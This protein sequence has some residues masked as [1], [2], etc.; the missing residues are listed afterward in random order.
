MRKIF[1]L[2]LWLS[3]LPFATRGQTIEDIAL[4][5][6]LHPIQAKALCYWYDDNTDNRQVVNN[7]SGTYTLDVSSLKDGLH[8]LYYQVIGTDDMSYGTT[9]QMFFR[10]T[11]SEEISSIPLD[12]AQLKYWYDEDTDNINAVNN[13]L[14][15]YSL[16]VSTLSDGLHT[17]H[18]ILVGA[19][20]TVCSTMSD[21]FIKDESIQ[22]EESLFPV[23]AARRVAYWF[24]DDA[25]NIQVSKGL[26]GT[27]K[28]DVSSLSDGLHLLHY[29]VVGE[30]GLPYGMTSTMF[31]KNESMY[32]QNTP[33]GITKY[34]YWLN[35]FST[36]VQTVT[37]DKTVNPYT[38]MT[39]LPAPKQPIRSSKFHF[40]V[41][42]GI[43]YIYAKN[44][45]H[46]RFYD[47][48]GEFVDNF[49]EEDNTYI[50]YSVKQEVT[51]ITLLESGVRAT[52][53]K[54]EENAIKW[55]KVT[56]VK[57]DSL[58][59]KLDRAATLQL[60]SPSGEEVFN[61]SGAESVKWGGCH[62]KEDGTFYVALHDVTAT[63][64]NDISIDYNHIDKY[65]V[66]RQD[67]N[68]VGNGGCS[69]I[70]FEGN[71][72]KDLYAVD[73]FNERGDTI[74]H[75]YIGHESDATTS[76]VFDFSDAILGIYSAKFR[77]AEEDKVFN[78]MVTVEE[79]KE[80]ELETTVTYP[81]TFL[82]G[83]STTYNIKITNKGNMTAYY[84]PLILRL[85][86]NTISDI[87]SLSI[88]GDIETS[89]ITDDLIFNELDEETINTIYKATNDFGN[90]PELAYYEDRDG[91]NVY[92]ITQIIL[93]IP[94]Y[95]TKDIVVN[96]KTSTTISLEASTS[97]E[98]QPLVIVASENAPKPVFKSKSDWLC[99]YRK[100]AECVVDAVSLLI[101]PG[102]SCASSVGIGALETIYDVW[103]SE[104]TNLSEKW[105]T[106][107][108]SKD[109][110]L[111]KRIIQ[112]VLSCVT[113]YFKNLKDKTIEDR[114]NAAISGDIEKVERL[115]NELEKIRNVEQGWIGS[116]F[117][118][119]KGLFVGLIGSDCYKAWS[120]E[121][122]CSPNST[123]GGGTSSPQRSYDPN[124]I[125]GY[126]AESGSHAVK[127]ELTNLYYTIQFEN[128][129]TF[130][131]AAAHDIY[132]TDTLDATKFD[133]ST[134]APTRVK[135]GEKA[136]NFTG[137]KNFVTTIDMRPE[138][139]AIAQVE[140]T[141]D[142]KKGIAMWHI[143]SLDP[144]TMEPTD[145]PMDGVLPINFNGNGIG[146]VSYDI[147][148]KSD[149]AHGTE[150]NN[151]AGIVFDKN[152]VIM[153]PTWKNVIDRISPESC[154]R[155]VTISSDTTATVSI[156]AKDELS[157]VWRYDVYV[158]YGPDA[159]WWKMAENV[160]ADT[161]A[162]VKIYEGIN[163]GFYVVVTDSAGNVEHKDAKREFTLNR[164]TFIRGDV[165]SDG[166][167]N[168]TDIQVIINFILVGR[169][170][171]KADLNKD[172]IVNGTDIQEIIN[173]IIGEE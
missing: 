88:N 172:G 154:I 62:A 160:P 91:N 97:K 1:F 95:T 41:N 168:G 99:C 84:L 81:S 137:D 89:S 37:L 112:S 10:M 5:E 61:A 78:N 56:A 158:Q 150:I 19:D 28:I 146:E 73:L 24:D 34:T 149:L 113:K 106:Y 102:A 118:G 58:Q 64:G 51:D 109:N 50:D 153:T 124:E 70:T 107:F 22:T 157:G 129:T 53:A 116:F 16:D 100:R 151:R 163:H 117:K 45:F 29:Y 76:V 136:A 140:G 93:T 46:I 77:F 47:A 8:T 3:C 96:V 67:V 18:A 65:A 134:F 39:L 35:D 92:G 142:D 135:I 30:D 2:F 161:T 138:I 121:L 42:D 115:T 145:D 141:F 25:N 152:D 83:S 36:P 17:L 103:C 101:P 171:E 143:S 44:D 98:W 173:I 82:Y 72:F 128:D 119:V 54:P 32:A 110:N 167:I 57:G 111:L 12:G 75:V 104:G 122:D 66:L 108:N 147:K 52:I 15:I 90:V 130:A 144:M 148:L 126:T 133:L 139:N 156:T 85:M 31:L 33:N 166:N 71:G 40:Q 20:G 38:L 123:G 7:L 169:Y 74:H 68:V 48:R 94:P 80:I 4:S 155:D 165:N 60:F 63:Y 170:E 9:S 21:F 59:F 125:Y 27:Y 43:P 159:P 55:Y 69:T 162:T 114:A 13:L 132:L 23:I 49:M 105:N 131:T 6:L 79:A 11:A 14:G 26:S 87:A 164:S 120:K 127:D 86:A